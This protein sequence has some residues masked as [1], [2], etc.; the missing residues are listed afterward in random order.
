MILTWCVVGCVC[1]WTDKRQAAGDDHGDDERL[2]VAMFDEWVGAAA[3][4]PEVAAQDRLSDHVATLAATVVE[5][6]R[7]AVVRVLYEHDAH[8]VYL[9]KHI[10]QP[11]RNP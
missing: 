1:L 5:T 8:F 2:E 6:F 11:S 9:L 10:Q 3:Q 7:T 4:R